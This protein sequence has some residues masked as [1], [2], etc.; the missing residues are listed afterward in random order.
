MTLHENVGDGFMDREK[1]RDQMEKHQFQH[2]IL[3]SLDYGGHGG[4]D[5]TPKVSMFQTLTDIHRKY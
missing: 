2:D 1:L 4:C 5:Y 3:Y